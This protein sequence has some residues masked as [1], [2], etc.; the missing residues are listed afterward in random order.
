M[1]KAFDPFFV[2]QK[3]ISRDEIVS[4]VFVVEVF[5]NGFLHKVHRFSNI[6]ERLWR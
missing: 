2:L 5:S 3:G 1:K 6:R 4:S